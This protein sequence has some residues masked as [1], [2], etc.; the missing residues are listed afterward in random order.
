MPQRGQVAVPALICDGEMKAE[1]A[2]LEQYIGFGVASSR[3]KS[4]YAMTMLSGRKR[5]SRSTAA[6]SRQHLN[7]FLSFKASWNASVVTVSM[8]Y[9]AERDARLTRNAVTTINVFT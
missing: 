1:Q 4:R 2:E 3:T 7:A 6:C 5:A 8:E 9:V